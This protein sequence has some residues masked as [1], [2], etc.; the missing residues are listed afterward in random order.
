MRAART[1]TARLSG[2]RRMTAATAEYTSPLKDYIEAM[3]RDETS[4]FGAQ[5]E[6]PPDRVLNCG[7]SESSLRY[8]TTSYGRLLQAPFV[9]ATEH[10]VTLQVKVDDLDLN[11]TEM[12]ILQQIVGSRLSST[13]LRLSS[14]QFGSRIENKRHLESMLNRIIVSSREL[15]AKVEPVVA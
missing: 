12:A 13:H 9:H 8:S 7:I 10:K 5:F 4:P 6:T 11:D 3:K 14:N 2:C 15:A 1:V